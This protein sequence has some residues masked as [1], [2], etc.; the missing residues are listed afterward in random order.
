[1]DDSALLELCSEF[2]LLVASLQRRGFDRDQAKD[3]VAEAMIC[4]YRTS[5][6]IDRSLRSWVG[7][8]AYRIACRQA[9]RA[10]EE[11][12]RAIDGGWAIAN[13]YDV[14]VVEI[15]EE[16]NRLLRLLQ[17][18]PRQQRRVM[19]RHLDGFN[20]RDISNDLDMH[21]A[22]VRAN[23]RHARKA[24]KRHVVADEQ[25]LRSRAGEKQWEA[26]QNGDPLPAAPR[27]AILNGW[28]MSQ[29][30]GVPPGR[31]KEVEPLD[32]DEVQRRSHVFPLT[33]FSWVLDALAELDTEQMVVV[34]D[35]DGVVLYRRGARRILKRADD[36]H[37]L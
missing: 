34:V 27:E 8:V 33:D 17:L 6:R 14:D 37:F 20:G 22:T 5:P 16:R 3:A 23:L 7:K 31:G 18:L 30:R 26:F 4:A 28:I 19:E 12:R 1:M 21:P 29:D 11:P 35:P 25:K 13:H 32:R 2:E 15:I 9:R 36:L 24:L 10:R